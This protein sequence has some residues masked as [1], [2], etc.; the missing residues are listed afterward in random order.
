MLTICNKVPPE[1]HESVPKHF[2]KTLIKRDAHSYVIE[3]VQR[4][5]A[6]QQVRV[7]SPSHFQ[8]FLAAFSVEELESPT[9]PLVE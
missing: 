7:F 3:R 8:G 5:L 9:L 1:K 2:G 6:C 4:L